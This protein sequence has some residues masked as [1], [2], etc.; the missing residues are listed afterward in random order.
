V[1]RLSPKAQGEL[2]KVL[3]EGE[4]ERLGGEE[5]IRVNVRVLAATNKNLKKEV[6]NE[7]FGVDL[8]YR[9]DRFSLELPP[10]RE[11]RTDIP[12]L[13]SY[14]MEKYDK[15]KRIKRLTD[16]VLRFLSYKYDWPGNVRE[17]ESIVENMIMSS[18]RNGRSII[19]L[20]DIPEKI[21]SQ[22]TKGLLRSDAGVGRRQTL[23]AATTEITTA[24]M[25]E[26]LAKAG[27]ELE[28]TGKKRGLVGRAAL[29]C[30]IS[31][32]VFQR[33]FKKYYGVPP[34]EYWRQHRDAL[35]HQ[36]G[37]SL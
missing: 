2:L 18:T 12:L 8:F 13:I 27:W 11:R 22:E 9:L 5:T 23:K 16:D 19:I 20:D 7:K 32:E 1:D 10:L 14:F 4:F 35:I 28:N 29:L 15:D 26:N 6:E 3:D 25:L 24:V 37:F 36:Y 17:V 30:E 34:E 31:R 21:L 33:K